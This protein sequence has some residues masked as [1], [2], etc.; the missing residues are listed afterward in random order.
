MNSHH[1]D[2]YDRDDYTGDWWQDYPDASEILPR[3]RAVERARAAGEYA[4]QADYHSAFWDAEGATAPGDRIRVAIARSGL[5]TVAPLAI[6]AERFTELRGEA[7]EWSV[8]S[9]GLLVLGV[10][11]HP[12]KNAPR[13]NS[14]HPVVEALTRGEIDSAI[15]RDGLFTAGCI[16][17][18]M[19]EK[20]LDTI[21]VRP[22]LLHETGLAWQCLRLRH[23]DII[24][25]PAQQ[26]VVRTDEPWFRQPW[27]WLV[28]S[29]TD[30]I[31]DTD[32]AL[33]LELSLLASC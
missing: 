31:Q 26:A 33:E 28:P 12:G 32:A 25:L 19:T 6:T 4:T 18:A 17:V 1:E 5:T 22:E 21:Y 7:P 14:R 23:G 3:L 29:F 9:D 27:R 24:P 20:T 13:W 10:T 30:V 8:S 15:T 2:R 16:T 11:R